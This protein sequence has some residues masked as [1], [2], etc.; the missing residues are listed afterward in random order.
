[1]PRKE[2]E[3]MSNEKR[4]CSTC[5][6]YTFPYQLCAKNVGLTHKKENASCGDWESKKEADE[7]AKAYGVY[8][9]PGTQG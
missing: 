8:Q 3:S 5:S 2:M 6:K 7:L 4:V 9:E 1:M